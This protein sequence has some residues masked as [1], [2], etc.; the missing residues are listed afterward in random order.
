M[1]ERQYVTCSLDVASP[2]EFMNV[3][4]CTVTKLENSQLSP[5]APERESFYRILC[6]L[7]KGW[8]VLGYRRA[9][10]LTLLPALQLFCPKGLC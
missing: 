9:L 3:L 4:F 10:E 7:K 6:K 5:Q 1:C 2:R 8:G